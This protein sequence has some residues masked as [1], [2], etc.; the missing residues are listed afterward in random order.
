VNYNGFVTFGVTSFSALSPTPSHW[1]S[2]PKYLGVY[3][4]DCLLD[5]KNMIPS[6]YIYH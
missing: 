2:S 3:W 4:T 6:I 1:P 5:L